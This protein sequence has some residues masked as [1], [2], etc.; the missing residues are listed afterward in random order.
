M[1]RCEVD[2]VRFCDPAATYGGPFIHTVELSD[3][4][5]LRQ[6]VTVWTKGVRPDWVARWP[7]HDRG[8]YHRESGGWLPQQYPGMESKGWSTH[9]HADL[10]LP[11]ILADLE[12]FLDEI[13]PGIQAE[14]QEY[15]GV[16]DGR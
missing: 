5:S 3:E 2:K 10:A 9:H 4:R 7:H 16:T 1:I 15:L 11:P 14:I 13:P 8:T 6:F 12:P